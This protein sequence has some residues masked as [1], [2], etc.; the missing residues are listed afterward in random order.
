MDS[1][2]RGSSEE[3][4]PESVELMKMIFVIFLLECNINVTIG[5]QYVVIITKYHYHLILGV[6]AFFLRNIEV[7]THHS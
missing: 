4:N 5:Y 2:P 3:R 7:S 6:K 1:I